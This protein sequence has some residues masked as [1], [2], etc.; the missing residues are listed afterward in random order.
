MAN[1]RC[2]G[3]GTISQRSSDKRWIGQITIATEDGKQKSS[4]VQ[5]KVSKLVKRNLMP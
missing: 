5:I 2:N 3:E 1:K 4:H